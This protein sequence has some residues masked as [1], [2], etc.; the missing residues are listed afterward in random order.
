M[1]LI[2]TCHKTGLHEKSFNLS[3]Y[4]S[5]TY[6]ECRYKFQDKNFFTYETL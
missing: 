2:H 4:T 5:F 1:S 6:E 3:L